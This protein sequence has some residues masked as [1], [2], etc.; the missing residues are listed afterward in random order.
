VID[1][2]QENDGSQSARVRPE[3]QQ[4]TQ[5]ETAND[6][7]QVVAENTARTTLAASEAASTRNNR[8][9][10]TRS[11]IG[12]SALILLKWSVTGSRRG[13]TPNSVA[14]P[15]TGLECLKFPRRITAHTQRF[16]TEQYT[17]R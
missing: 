7:K 1:Q 15:A 3:Y 5:Y 16:Y 17:A 2:R 4:Q 9:S 12:R 8:G 11:S 14:S 13:F 6:P 10:G